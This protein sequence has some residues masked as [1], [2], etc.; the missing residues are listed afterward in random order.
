VAS[1]WR[2]HRFVTRREALR[3]LRSHAPTREIAIEEVRR[4]PRKGPQLDLFSELAQPKQPA[5]NL[6][7]IPAYIPSPEASSGTGDRDEDLEADDAAS[8]DYW[9]DEIESGDSD[10]LDA[11]EEFDESRQAELDDLSYDEPDLDDL[12]W[13]DEDV[14]P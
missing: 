2:R 11:P 12:S 5:E 10:G 6:R 13:E 9:D 4:K 14:Y 7:E 8:D 3:Q 1:P